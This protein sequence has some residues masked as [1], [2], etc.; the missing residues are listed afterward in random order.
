MGTLFV[1]YLFDHILCS[2][3]TLLISYTPYC[4]RFLSKSF[5]ELQAELKSNTESY[6]DSIKT[7]EAE[8]AEKERRIVQLEVEL[9]T[10][11]KRIVELESRIEELITEVEKEK[12]INAGLKVNVSELQDELKRAQINA[13]NFDKVESILRKEVE[14]YKAQLSEANAE[15]TSQ[16]QKKAELEELISKTKDSLVDEKSRVA[17]AL[18]EKDTRIAQLDRELAEKYDEIRTTKASLDDTTRQLTKMTTDY[19][20]QKGRASTLDK[21]IQKLNQVTSGASNTSEEVD[22]LTS[23]LEDITKS[24]EEYKSL[25][26][27]YEDKS[28]FLSQQLLLS[29]QNVSTKQ[30]QIEKLRQ[31]L[32]DTASRKQVVLENKKSETDDVSVLRTKLNEVQN[33]SVSWKAQANGMIVQLQDDLKEKNQSMAQMQEQLDELSKGQQQ[34][35][36]PEQSSRSGN[37]ALEKEIAELKSAMEDA[38]MKAKERMKD[39]NQSLKELEDSVA[40]LSAEMIDL[41]RDK[42]QLTKRL[43]E[44]IQRG[45]DVYQI[46][47]RQLK[48]T[49]DKLAKQ[50]IA[51]MRNLEAEMS[52]TIHDLEREVKSLQDQPNSPPPVVKVPTVQSTNM[53]YEKVKRMQEELRRSREVEVSLLNDN[54]KMKKRLDALARETYSPPKPAKVFDDESTDRVKKES[55]ELP[56][57][58]KE[59]Q[60]TA[61][62]R[63]V[64]NTWNKL[65]RRKK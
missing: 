17:S 6:E 65:F 19:N 25:M 59:K 44:E 53:E 13:G 20:S 56:K 3:A 48:E 34:A 24:N 64:K 60:R 7:Y 9:E 15:T 40:K 29:G 31:E 54:M 2:R 11:K 49:E 50:N 58:Y 30:S 46:H 41:R 4:T 62:I 63:V 10:A 57:Y 28:K 52:A 8:A 12:S 16:Q 22:R 35:P 23:L 33:K 36:P 39:K 43:N 14:T 32:E 55:V 37:E 27:T 1:V 5:E 51:D 42:D 61:V 18:S 45:K 26:A 47:D 38:Q 21:K